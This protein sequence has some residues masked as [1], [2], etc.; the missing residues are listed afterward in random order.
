M[1]IFSPQGFNVEAW[2]HMNG[3]YTSSHVTIYIVGRWLKVVNRD[4]GGLILKITVFCI[5]YSAFQ[6][7][8]KN[9]FIWN[10][11]NAIFSTSPKII[12]WYGGTQPRKTGSIFLIFSLSLWIKK[13]SMIT[14]TNRFFLMARYKIWKT[15]TSN[16]NLRKSNQFFGRKSFKRNSLDL[17]NVESG[18]W[19]HDP[20]SWF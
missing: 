13:F 15:S 18:R 16:V 9:L 17:T 12:F 14:N 11:K 2:L 6:L 8:L 1:C 19:H 20:L 4:F 7:C 3:T 10:D 5:D